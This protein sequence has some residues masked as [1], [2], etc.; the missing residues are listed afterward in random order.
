MP[1]PDIIT[2]DCIMKVL[3][4]SRPEAY[5]VLREATRWGVLRLAM[6]KNNKP[7]WGHYEVNWRAVG[8]VASLL[9]MNIG[10][11]FDTLTP[12]R[13]VKNAYKYYF[14]AHRLAAEAVKEFNEFWRATRVQAF[15]R[16]PYVLPADNLLAPPP[17]LP[18][19]PP[20]GS[21]LRYTLL[22]LNGRLVPALVLGLG[23]IYLVP[24]GIRGGAQ[25][26]FPCVSY[27]NGKFLCAGSLRALLRLL[28]LPDLA[29]LLSLPEPFPYGGRSPRLV[30]D[31]GR[32]GLVPYD[33]FAPLTDR[34][35]VGLQLHDSALL[36]SCLARWRSAV[37]TSGFLLPEGF[38]GWPAL[39]LQ[40]ASGT[41]R[42][43]SHR[44]DVI[45]RDVLHCIDAIRGLIHSAVK[46]L[47]GSGLSPQSSVPYAIALARTVTVQAVD[48]PTAAY[49]EVLDGFKAREGKNVYRHE[50]ARRLYTLEE[51]IKLLRTSDRPTTVMSF[52]VIV[53]LAD[54][55]YLK[56]AIDFGFIYI[57]H[58]DRKDPPNAVR[59]EFRAYEGVT[60]ALGKEGTMRLALGTLFML[61]QALAATYQALASQAR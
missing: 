53:P 21:V 44:P 46:G 36:G 51:F 15:A 40:P 27:G 35:E 20:K 5:K 10:F 56:E 16:A 13:Q 31:V 1:R 45:L 9:P 2:P 33:S 6:R 59:A 42:L 23:N 55:P 11:D 30:V 18:P 60:E 61:D 50:G 48:P 7:W 4:V 19:I 34:Y 3:R 38:K 12:K 22:E 49:V 24:V 52:R 17:S 47:R 41:N 29:S 39:V 32:P 14:G 28:G 8:Y 43:V 58:N 26:C 54:A 37:I 25:S 57:Y